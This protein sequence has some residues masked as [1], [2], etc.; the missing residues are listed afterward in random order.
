[1]GLLEGSSS[2][3]QIRFLGC[4]IAMEKIEAPSSVTDHPSICMDGPAAI[5]CRPG[6]CLLKHTSA[7]FT[8]LSFSRSENRNLCSRYRYVK[9]STGIFNEYGGTIGVS[10]AIDRWEWDGL[11]SYKVPLLRIKSFD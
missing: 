9:L 8:I 6:I 10:I 2:Y 4:L 7:V 11:S 1:M 5:A 3:R